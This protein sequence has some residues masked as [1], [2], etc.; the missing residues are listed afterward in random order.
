MKIPFLHATTVAQLKEEIPANLDNYRS[1]NFDVLIEDESLTFIPDDCPEGSEKLFAKINILDSHGM[2]KTDRANSDVVY[3]EMIFEAIN[4]DTISPYIAKDERFWIY[5]THTL[6]LEYSRNRFPISDNDEKAIKEIKKHFFCSDLNRGLERDNTASRIWW[7]AYLA[8]RVDSLSL[9]EVLNILLYRTDVRA[10]II[11]RPTTS[12]N[13]IIFSGIIKTLNLSFKTEEKLLF[14]RGIFRPF[15]KELN[16]L[17][18]IKLLEYMT[19]DESKKLISNLL[20][21]EV[22]KYKNSI[23]Q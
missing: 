14:E 7:N 10:S 16:I 23:A 20:A 2:T 6:L 21:S 9:S 5:I 17:G 11:E 19:E 8:S 13:S 12:Q 4:K 1:G 22:V 15:M 18:G 3:S